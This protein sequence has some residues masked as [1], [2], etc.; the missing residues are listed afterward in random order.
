MQ[1]NQRTYNQYGFEI[2]FYEH[3]TRAIKTILIGSVEVTIS[4]ETRYNFSQLRFWRGE[5]YTRHGMD[6]WDTQEG[7]F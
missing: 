7:G 5:R 2:R 4:K 3:P 1:N 6:P